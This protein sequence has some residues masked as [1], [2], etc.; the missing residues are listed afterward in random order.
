M[1][2]LLLACLQEKVEMKDFE[3]FY[4][5][6][7]AAAYTDS[8]AWPLVVHLEARGGKASD[9]VVR[10]SGHAGVVVV[11][12][13][14]DM[15]RER[16]AGFVRA[17]LDDAKSRVRI[18]PE[19]VLLTGRDD[20]AEVA[21]AIAIA[22]PELFA[23]CAPFGLRS[24]PEVKGKV[25]PFHMVLRRDADAKKQ[26]REAAS[27]LANSGVDVMARVGFDGAEPDE[28]AVLEWFASKAASRG[29]LEAV[30][31]FLG[32]RRY[33]DAS[34]VCLGL[35]DRA[36]QERFVRV[37]LQKIE[38]AGI[39]A[40]G[41]VEVAMSDKRY[42]DAVLRCRDAAIQFSWV[43]VGEKLRQRRAELEADPRVKRARGS[44][45]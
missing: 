32:A 22:E 6:H 30:D 20:A 45:D 28:P 5:L 14:R 7:K 21:A 16:E 9:G 19:L 34:L 33:L 39:V 23:A 4:L 41:S 1:I 43:P 26:G 25:P 17:C 24:A 2:L 27:S 44:E 3:S 8:K 35:I 11:P 42:V 37:R 12:Q 40:L 29:D 18:D 13:R 10:W 31:R 38:A 15:G 36:G